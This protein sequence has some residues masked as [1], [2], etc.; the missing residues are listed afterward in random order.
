M[1]TKK[2]FDRDKWL[3]EKRAKV[4]DAKEMLETGLTALRTSDEWKACMTAIAKNARLR[5]SVTRYSFGN[6][7]MLACQCAGAN[8][9]Q[10]T[11]VATF[12]AW[13]RVGRSVK[14]GEKG[15]FILT[16]KPWKREEKQSDGTSKE[17]R[18]MSFGVAHVFDIAQ[19]EGDELPVPPRV[20]V[21]IEDAATFSA[22]V[23]TLREVALAIDGEPVSDI[24]IRANQPGD[25]TNAQGW[26]VISTKAIVVVEH[27]S[28]AHMFK[29]LVHEVAH[30]LLHPKGDHHSTPEREVEA[31]STAFIVCQ[32]LGL[33]TDA[34]SFPYVESWAQRASC[35][36]NDMIAKCGDRITKASHTILDALLGKQVE[37]PNE[38]EAA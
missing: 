16:P 22:D 3:E 15:M 7:M 29:T 6:Q 18:G 21:D 5:Y 10:P 11:S 32:V 38:E 25:P 24:E 31:E 1:P 23:E 30:A 28:R 17:L 4:Q 27:R 9:P 37:E 2:P 13:Q 33:S 20:T 8:R 12:K 14:K 36:S 35:T 34:F 26:Y 19:T